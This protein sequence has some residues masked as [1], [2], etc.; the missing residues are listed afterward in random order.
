MR[1][2]HD[3][4]REWTH[5]LRRQLVQQLRDRGFLTSPL[6]AAA[7]SRAPRHAFLA[8]HTFWL[9]EE[10]DRRHSWTQGDQAEL[11]RLV[12]CD[13]PLVIREAE[14]GTIA[15]SSTS[16]SLVAQMVELLGVAVG[17]RVLEIGTGSG[18]ATAI[19]AELVG[20][21][22]AVE[23]VEIDQELA[24]TASR[25]LCSHGYQHASAVAGDATRIPLGSG[26]FDRIL[27][28]VATTMIP[29]SWLDTLHPGGTLVVSWPLAWRGLV[30]MVRKHG[31]GRGS[32]RFVRNQ[33]RTCPPLAGG[34]ARTGTAMPA[35]DLH[36]HPHGHLAQFGPRSVLDPE[37]EPGLQLLAK[38]MVPGLTCLPFTAVPG[39]DRAVQFVD[40]NAGDC[41]VVIDDHGAVRAT[42]DGVELVERLR[43]TYELWCASGRPAEPEYRWSW[44]TGEAQ[45]MLADGTPFERGTGGH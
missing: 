28:S 29:D 41:S 17:E 30:L 16:P 11:L 22:G 37:I 32:G 33:G 18:Y 38:W 13:R 36:R 42:D 25:A 15:S 9:P 10:P 39:G 1:A 40:V 31:E 3:D 14:D 19:L 26:R 7:I 43:A 20:T 6:V 24:E 8:E 23:T 44:Q 5:E 12:Y 2:S 4:V 45:L 34:T 21:G 35:K 27:G